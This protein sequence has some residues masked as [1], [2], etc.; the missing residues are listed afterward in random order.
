[1]RQFFS[2]RFAPEG[3]FPPELAYHDN[4]PDLF[5]RLGYRWT[6]A[7]DGTMSYYGIDV[8]YD[9]IYTSHGIPV[10]LRSNHWSNKLADA[11]YVWRHGKDFVEELA[12][13]MKS[14]IGE[15]DGYI[16]IALDGETF[17][18]HRRSLNESFLREM[19]EAFHNCDLRL[20]HLS[21]L[22]RIFPHR[23]QF[24]PPSSWSTDLA[25][26]INRDYF[27]WWKSPQNRV[28]TLQW[29]LTDYVAA[30][31][32]DLA[33]HEELRDEMDQALY[34]CQYWW[35]S[36]WRFNADEVCKGVFNLMRILHHVAEIHGDRYDELA[37]GERICRELITEIELEHNRR[38]HE[39]QS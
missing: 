13:G 38:Q 6:L 8:P 11:Q 7:D 16:V 36:F 29:E 25:G 28:H 24:L 1:M 10:F 4:L 37:E 2:S 35:A 17:G 33:A 21:E 12:R 27:S 9:D 20:A 5:R 3:V 34:S 14:W 22:S 39:Q 31:V 32:N 30:K 23:P 18:H 26:V 19:F 15:R